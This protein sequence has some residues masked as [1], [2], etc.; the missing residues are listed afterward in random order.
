MSWTPLIL[1]I[2]NE[3]TTSSTAPTAPTAPTATSS[4]SAAATVGDVTV[5]ATTTTAIVISEFKSVAKSESTLSSD[6]NVAKDQEKQE[7]KKHASALIEKVRSNLVPI[8]YRGDDDDGDS[9]SDSVTNKSE[10]KYLKLIQRIIRKGKLKLDRTGIGTM[11]LSGANIRYCL[12]NG[13]LPLLTTKKVDARLVFEELAWFISGSTYERELREKKCKIWKDNA[14]D[15]DKRFLSSKDKDADADCKHKH[16]EG[17]L[18]PVYGHAWRHFGAPYIDCKTDYTGQGVD[19][20]ANIV[21]MIRE[22]PNSRRILLSAWDP[23]VVDHCALPP[24]HVLYQWIVD[25]ENGELDCIMYQRSADIGL[26]VPFNI[27]SASLLTIMLAHIT[28]LRPGEFCHMMGD[29]HIYLNHLEAL[30]EQ[31]KREPRPFPTLRIKVPC[32]VSSKSSNQSDISASAKPST[33]S[34]TSSTSAVNTGVDVDADASATT[35]SKYDEP[36]RLQNLE[37]F[38]FEHLEI[39]NYNPH[40]PISMKMAV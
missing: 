24:C 32:T 30:A 33:S 4:M 3:A 19:Q 12:R 23:R 28:G 5:D 18:G 14:D 11:Y 2:P 20:I 37:D 31:T 17:D 21:R 16:I 6:V 22:Q 36:Q 29:A 27:C 8:T 40:P 1:R 25:Q 15:F 34:S 7:F 13:K 39:S 35:W 26:G 38:R 9:D 10:I